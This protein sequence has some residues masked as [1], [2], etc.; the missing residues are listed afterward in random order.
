MAEIRIQEK[1]NPIWPWI[2]LIIILIIAAVLLYM[3]L[4][5]DNGMNN[6]E[7]EVL[8]DTTTYYEQDTLGGGTMQTPGDEVEQFSAFTTQDTAGTFSKDYVIN[9]LNMLS[10]ALYSIVHRGD[11]VSSQIV[12][13]TDSLMSYTMNLTDTSSRSFNR[14]VNRSMNTAYDIISTLQKDNYPNL[15]KQV[16]ELRSAIR[17][18][19]SSK[20]V[21]SQE[22]P[23]RNF[24][25]ISG[26][27]LTEMNNTARAM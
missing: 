27:V 10:G 20:P 8:P 11:T 7:R 16:S 13:S 4:N 21:E 22:K 26:S 14:E 1:K 17:N 19:D 12:T 24:F 23:V 2:L 15:S 18:Y 25:R 5:R 3:Y 6:D 9:G